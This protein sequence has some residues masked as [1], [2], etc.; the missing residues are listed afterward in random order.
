MAK[1]ISDTLKQDIK[2]MEELVKLLPQKKKRETIH[3]ARD[4][5]ETYVPKEI[6]GA[7]LREIR[8]LLDRVDPTQTWGQLQKVLTPEGHFLW[9]C[10]QHAQE[11]LV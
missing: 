2:L 1:D 10:D 3:Y 5:T 4:V 7:L 8:V 11:Y 9:V 6:S